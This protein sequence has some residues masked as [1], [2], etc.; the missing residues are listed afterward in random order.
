MSTIDER[1]GKFDANRPAVRLSTGEV[2][3]EGQ[4]R[5]LKNDPRYWDQANADR[6]YRAWVDHLYEV[7]YNINL[8]AGR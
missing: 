6:D 2:L 7:T 1:V 4:L 5:D 8:K 3:T